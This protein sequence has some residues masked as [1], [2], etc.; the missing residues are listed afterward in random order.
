M[1]RSAE[2]FLLLPILAFLAYVGYRLAVAGDAG[3]QS[4]LPAGVA[5][6]LPRQRVISASTTPGGPGAA[7]VAIPA[8]VSAAT[9][10][11]VTQTSIPTRTPSRTPAATPTVSPTLE[12]TATP[13]ATLGVSGSESTDGIQVGMRVV[14]AIQEYAR[15]KGRLPDSLDALVPEQ[16]LELPTTPIGQPYY[17]RLFSPDEFLADELFWLS[18]RVLSEDDTVCTYYARL[19]AWDCNH[20]SP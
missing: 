15:A 7:V 1:R 3:W 4:G 8:T 18:F 2:L 19:G 17:Y 5:T 9:L 6:W 14:E 16:L 13:T 12:W 11:P 20:H 10:V